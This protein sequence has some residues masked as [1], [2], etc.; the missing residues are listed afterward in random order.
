ML[1]VHN[2]LMDE[3]DS[4]NPKWREVY[5]S[6]GSAAGAAGVEGLFRQWL[7]T[8]Q[9]MKYVELRVTKV[10]WTEVTRRTKKQIEADRAL[11]VVASR[12]EER[13]KTDNE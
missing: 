3:L 8:P 10:D 7:V 2:E 4:F 9:G 5:S 11:G 6:V 12:H 13:F 1:K